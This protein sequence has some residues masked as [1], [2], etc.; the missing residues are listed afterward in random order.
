MD[1]ILM[2]EELRSDPQNALKA[3]GSNVGLLP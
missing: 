1:K 3:G 2:N